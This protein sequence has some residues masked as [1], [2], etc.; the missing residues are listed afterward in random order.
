M[1]AD[2]GIYIL[3]TKDNQ[4]R[5]AHLSAID[6]AYYSAIGG[7]KEL[8]V[9]TR[10]VEMWGKCKF[11]RDE[12]KALS[13]A[14]KWASKLP[15]CEYGVNV[16]TYNKTWKHILEDARE[17]A[18]KEILHIKKWNQTALWDMDELQRIADGYYLDEYLNRKK[19]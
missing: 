3:K 1:S 12:S 11:T 15:I 10:V 17:H 13:M 19:N 5:V 18:R 16:L 6:N 7:E 8:L 14:H 9:P 2:N 4:Y